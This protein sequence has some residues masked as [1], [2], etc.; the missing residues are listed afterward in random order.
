MVTNRTDHGAPDGAWG[1]REAAEAW[2]RQASA[3]AELLGAATEMLLDG[4]GVRAGTRVL[5]IAAGTGDQT[6]M[7]A[8]RA[9]RP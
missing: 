7:A 8:R 5:D 6:L 3:R 9:G 2:R 4:A 1:S